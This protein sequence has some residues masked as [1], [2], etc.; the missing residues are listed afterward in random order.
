MTSNSLQ[1]VLAW[2][3]ASRSQQRKKPYRPT[4]SAVATAWREINSSV[5]GGILTQPEI[6]CRRLRG[7]WGECEGYNEPLDSGSY[8]RIIMNYRWYSH[9]WMINVLAHEMVHQWQWEHQGKWLLLLGVNPVLDHGYDFQSWKPR[10]QQHGL[11]LC[12]VYD[13]DVWF[14]T[15]K[16]QESCLDKY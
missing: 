3:A 11:T 15:G 5:F 6:V 8:C 4:V 2:P 14:S 9:H 13:D 12:H 7:K 10:F 16:F 1:Q